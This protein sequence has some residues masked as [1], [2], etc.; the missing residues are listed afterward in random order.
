MI[1]SHS[2]GGRPFF[3][4]PLSWSDFMFVARALLCVVVLGAGLALGC[5][6]NENAGKATGI[7]GTDTSVTGDGGI[8]TGTGGTGAGVT[9]TSG[10]EAATN[11]GADSADDNGTGG[12][13]N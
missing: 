6:R 5:N 2:S 12:P 8:S 9:G 3:A 1:A 4:F 13:T 11:P 10:D 7:Y